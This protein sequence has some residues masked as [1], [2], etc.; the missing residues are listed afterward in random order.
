[1]ATFVMTDAFV[2][3]NAVDLSDHVRSVTLSYSAELQDDTVMGDTTRSRTGGL[4][5]WSLE[6]EFLQD[7]AA[8]KVDATLFTL[9]G[10]TSTIIVRPDNSDGVSAT[11]PNFT[12][13]AILESYNP[14]T[15]S[16]GEMAT[17]TASF[18]AAGALSRAVA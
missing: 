14:G 12:G 4:K 13:T 7:Y 1:M 17:A 9:V 5:D 11:N 18:Q 16:L 10:S 8:S 3:I 2:S 15:G 6:V